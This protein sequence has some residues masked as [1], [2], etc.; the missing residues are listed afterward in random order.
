MSLI[1]CLIC[2]LG[3]GGALLLNGESLL[4]AA[5]RA[6][7]AVLVF[8]FIQKFLG[9]ILDISTGASESTTSQIEIPEDINAQES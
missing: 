2:F 7:I 8:Y 9:S 3:V 6:T 1:L 4:T 5:V